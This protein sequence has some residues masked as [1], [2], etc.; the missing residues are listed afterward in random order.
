MTKPKT[1][2]P[3]AGRVHAS[4]AAELL[5]EAEEDPQTSDI[6]SRTL[7]RAQVHATLALYYQNGTDA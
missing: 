1:Y 3:A 2:G 5:K 7:A 4:K 6:Q